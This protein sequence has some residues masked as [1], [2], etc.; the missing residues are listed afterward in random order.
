M[1]R[2]TPPDPNAAPR[3]Y[4]VTP[5]QIDPEGF[6]AHLGAVLAAHPV[7]CLRLDLATAEESEW[8]RAI[9][10]LQ[11]V[12][13]AAEVPLLVRE[14]YRLVTPYGLDGVHLADGRVSLRAVRKA[15]GGD[16]IIGAFGGHTRHD[17][18]TLAEAGADYVSFGPLKSQGNLGAEALAEGDLFQWWAEMIET[19]VVAEGSV[20]PEDIAHLRDVA[21]LFAIDPALWEAPDPAAE[22]GRYEAALRQ[23]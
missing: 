13:H 22:L 15:L 7:A 4:L 12:C 10:Y 23:D 17:G 8:V 3:L 20:S 9:N 2:Q 16:R 11:P 1:A 18:M 5:R 6:A 14:H 21:D 19:P